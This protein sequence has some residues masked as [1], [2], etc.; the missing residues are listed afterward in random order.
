MSREVNLTPEEQE[1]I[2]ENLKKDSSEEF[3]K[4]IDQMLRFDDFKTRVFANVGLLK[5]LKGIPGLKSQEINRILNSVDNEERND[6]SDSDFLVDPDTELDQIFG[7]DNPARRTMTK[8]KNLHHSDMK[9][10]QEEK[11]NLTNN[12]QILKERY[13]EA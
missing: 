8:I 4:Y 2:K 10:L 7:K 12:L 1:K 3:I 9:V 13:E 5:V 11:T 6:D